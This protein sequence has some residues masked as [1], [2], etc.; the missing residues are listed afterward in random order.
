MVVGKDTNGHR[1]D[2]IMEDETID[3]AIQN[4]KDSFQTSIRKTEF[5]RIKIAELNDNEDNFH[6][7]VTYE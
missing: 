5:I 2:R 1:I 4:F 6:S 3:A 7:P